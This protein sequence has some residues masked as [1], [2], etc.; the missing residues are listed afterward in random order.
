MSIYIDEHEADLSALGAEHATALGA[1][2]TPGT[3]CVRLRDTN[4]H[5]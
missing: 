2:N 3:I 1:L 5:L 4:M